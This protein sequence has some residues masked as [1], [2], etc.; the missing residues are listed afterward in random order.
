[1]RPLTED[2]PARVPLLWLA[3][4]IPYIHEDKIHFVCIQNACFC[5]QRILIPMAVFSLSNL[6][7]TLVIINYPVVDV[8]MDLDKNS[9]YWKVFGKLFGKY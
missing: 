1:M 7:A 2:L 3:L 6:I 9:K 8:V 4:Q 5:V